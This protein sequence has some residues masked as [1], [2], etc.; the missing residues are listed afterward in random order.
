MVSGG[1][2]GGGGGGGVSAQ[3]FASSAALPNQQSLA[4]IRFLGPLFL[5]STNYILPL[6]LL[7]GFFFFVNL[8]GNVKMH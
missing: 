1:L 8:E 6:E 4:A 5:S 2:G 3:N 7:I